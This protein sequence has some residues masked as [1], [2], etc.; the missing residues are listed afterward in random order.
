MA[1]RANISDY[2]DD[3]AVANVFVDGSIPEMFF[4]LRFAWAMVV[5]V[6]VAGIAWCAVGSGTVMLVAVWSWAIIII[7]LSL[8]AAVAR[9]VSFADGADGMIYW[10]IAAASC[11]C[12]CAARLMIIWCCCCCLWCWLFVFS[13]FYWL[14][15]FVFVILWCQSRQCMHA[16]LGIV[17]YDI[18]EEDLH[19]LSCWCFWCSLDTTFYCLLAGLRNMKE[20]VYKKY[21]WGKPYTINMEKESIYKH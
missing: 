13:L 16:L 9:L 8:I 12:C 18:E 6:M 10:W 17:W 7:I 3:D 21:M 4:G 2:L 1:Q 5:V 15:L 14:L 11:H 19:F 20:L